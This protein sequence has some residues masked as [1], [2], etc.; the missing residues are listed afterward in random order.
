MDLVVVLVTIIIG[1]L[2]I[3]CAFVCVIWQSVQ[4]EIRVSDPLTCRQVLAC[5]SYNDTGAINQ[6]SDVRS[7]AIPN[8]RLV[9]AFDIDNSF[10]TSE[11]E[12]R[13]EFNLEAIKA[14]KMT[15]VEVGTK[16]FSPSYKLQYA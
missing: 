8:K 3:V 16:A 13:K 6:Y 9:L 4:K 1:L 12:R 15:E 11:A 14:I 5:K 10:T 7:R 2:A